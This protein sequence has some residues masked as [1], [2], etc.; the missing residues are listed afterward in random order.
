MSTVFC[1][2]YYYSTTTMLRTELGVAR[3]AIK[4]AQQAI[5]CN[6]Y[7]LRPYIVKGLGLVKLNKTEDALLLWRGIVAKIQSHDRLIAYDIALLDDITNLIRE[8]SLNDTIVPSDLCEGSVLVASAAVDDSA[9]IGAVQDQQLDAPVTLSNPLTICTTIKGGVTDP[10]DGSTSSGG[11]AKI[12]KDGDDEVTVVAVHADSVC[13]KPSI[14]PSPVAVMVDA[15]SPSSSSSSSSSPGKGNK[16]SVKRQKKTARDPASSSATISSSMGSAATKRSTDP[17]TT[18]TTTATTATTA[19]T[20]AA[21]KTSSRMVVSTHKK[22]Q[23]MQSLKDFHSRTIG[24]TDRH[25]IRPFYLVSM[26]ENLPQLSGEPILD[27]LVCVAYININTGKDD[28]AINIFNLIMEYRKD[29]P[30]VC[31]GLGSIYAMQRKFDDAIQQFSNAVDLNPDLGEAYKR[32]GQT[33]AAKGQTATALKDLSKAVSLCSSDSGDSHFQ[34]GL[35][36]HQVKNHHHH[37]HHHHYHHQHHHHHYHHHHDHHHHHLIYQIK[38]YT[39]GLDDFR[40]A[41]R[42][43]NLRCVYPALLLVGCGPSCIAMPCIYLFY[44]FYV[45][46]SSHLL[47]S[48]T[49]RLIVSLSHL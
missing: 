22:E 25:P 19:A 37:Q 16:E 5:D 35:L 6:P 12:S 7:N 17:S 36:F 3:K 9:P 34:R 2:Y 47:R 38:N 10:L 41:F 40:E 32:R 15:S 45:T 20:T 46:S 24:M 23:A 8:H 33:R 48:D 21:S 28:V 14:D 29:L 42:R 1:T 11:N 39:K 27:D 26:R 4:S 44:L 18:A 49:H 31:I 30:S 13:I 43:G